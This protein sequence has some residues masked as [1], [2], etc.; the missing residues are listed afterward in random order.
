MEKR[1]LIIT[2]FIIPFFHSMT[3]HHYNTN[4]NALRNKDMLQLKK[5]IRYMKIKQRC[6]TLKKETCS[7]CCYLLGGLVFGTA[8]LANSIVLLSAP[9]TDDVEYAVVSNIGLAA[10]G[11]ASGLALGNSYTIVALKSL[12]KEE[13]KLRIALLEEGI[14]EARLENKD[15][16][17]ELLNIY[18]QRYKELKEQLLLEHIA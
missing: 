14:F 3:M 6:A 18:K 16:Y 13:E 15:E 10:A 9:S 7:P 17:P 2:L 12:Q 8:F 11:F 1:F 4:S 5:Q